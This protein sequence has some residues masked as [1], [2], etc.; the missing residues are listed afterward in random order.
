MFQCT[1][2]ESLLKGGEVAIVWEDEV[3]SI[4]I[5]CPP[6]QLEGAFRNNTEKTVPAPCRPASSPGFTLLENQSAAKHN[7]DLFLLLL[8]LQ[9]SSLLL[10]L[11]LL[12][13]TA[14]AR[15]HHRIADN[16]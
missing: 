14:Q 5:P 4:H 9:I 1:I 13:D 12:S 10:L 2:E 3:A 15:L 6:K 7:H 11:L 16:A 8:W